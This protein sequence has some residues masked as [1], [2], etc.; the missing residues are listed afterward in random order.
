MLG[1]LVFSTLTNQLL[2]E[3]GNEWFNTAPRWLVNFYSSGRITAELDEVV[4]V[5][6]VIPHPVNQSYEF[7][8]A[9]VVTH[10]DD[11]S[12]RNFDHL[13]EII[14]SKKRQVTA[15]GTTQR[16]VITGMS[17]LPV[18]VKVVLPM[19]EAMEA[20]KVLANLY[21]VPAQYW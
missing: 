20:D 11:V 14:Q 10:V 3:W 9:R 16:V 19:R 21:Q 12:I 5:V 1:G 2:T 7:M 18:P 8:Y 4:V 6:Q 15:D 17:S 13:K